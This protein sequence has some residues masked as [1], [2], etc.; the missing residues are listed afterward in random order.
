M[1]R[2]IFLIAGV[3][4][5]LVCFPLFF[6][7]NAYLLDIAIMVLFWASLAGAWNIAAGYGGQLSLGH[8]AFVGIG[9]YTST[10]LLIRFHL[11]P[12]LGMVMGCGIAGM[13]GIFLG[14]VCFRLKGP[15]F[16]LATIAF[17]EVLRILAI[18]LR[19]ITE[20]AEGLVIPFK[21]GFTSFM[22][23]SRVPYYY[24]FLALA[25]AILG[26][27]FAIE[28]SRFG[29]RLLASRQ[30]EDA[31]LS[32]GIQVRRVRTVAMGLSAAMTALCGSFYAQYIQFVEP[33][34]VLSW[35]FS[36]QPALITIVGGVGTV[37]GPFFGSIIIVP[38]EYLL[39]GYLGEAYG[40][41]YIVVYGSLVALVVLFLP[42]GFLWTARNLLKTKRR[43]S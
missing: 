37:L 14:A 2:A 32:I 1:I 30:E 35:T 6:Y 22:F 29:Y 10:L 19:S 13:V 24:F 15:F 36:I 43:L 9:A 31:A 7:K 8:A 40:P 18:N 20:G 34:S 38:M 4:I 26:A 28:K 16:I 11:S 12:W 17:A 21:P 33:D 41:L 3:F 27:C 5:S 25:C 23:Q 42:H 39:R